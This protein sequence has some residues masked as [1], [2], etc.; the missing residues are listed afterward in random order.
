MK[1]NMFA[2]VASMLLVGALVAASLT[3][4]S[5]STNES[6][7]TT[8]SNTTESSTTESSTAES[9]K[10]E[11]SAAESSTKE[12]STAES[13]TA[14]EASSEAPLS[15]EVNAAGSSALQ[16]LAQAAAEAFMEKNPDLAVNVNGGGSGE[17]CK[18]VAAG[19]IDIGNSDVDASEKIDADAAKALVD[20]KVCII[21]NAAIVNKD[22]GITNLTTDQLIDIFTGKV[23]NWKD[24]G[25]PDLE[26][27][28]CTR[29]ASSGTRAL[30]KTYALNGQEETTGLEND[31]SGELMTTV[32]QNKGA[33]GYL[34]LSYLVDNDSVQAVS[35][36]GVEPTLENTYNGTYKVWGYE[37]MYTNGEGS[38][39]AQAFINYIMSDEFAPNIEKMGYGVTSK[40]SDAAIK[41]HE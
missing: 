40:L 20:H 12:S 24:V 3:G 19:T 21:T 39:Q 22:L 25:G 9:S 41:T 14:A 26:I 28:L 15:G 34:A 30:F 17:G 13:S 8:E 16:P 2:K 32:A 5:S 7:G 11:S 1:K 10:A 18:Q 36:D 38:E 35:I 4:C 31:N 33:I 37:H 27:M 23:T 6:S 29:P